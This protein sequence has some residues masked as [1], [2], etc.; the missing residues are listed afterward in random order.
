MGALSRASRHVY[1][2]GF[3]MEVLDKYRGPRGLELFNLFMVCAR[4][5]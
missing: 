3:M 4:H 2:Q 5:P 1:A